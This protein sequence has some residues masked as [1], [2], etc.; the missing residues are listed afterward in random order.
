MHLLSQIMNFKLE[1]YVAQR[2]AIYS[3]L[4]IEGSQKAQHVSSK[5]IIDL[6]ICQYCFFL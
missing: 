5:I 3:L 1:K 6:H 4:S 2:V